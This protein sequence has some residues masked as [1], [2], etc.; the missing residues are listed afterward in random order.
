MPELRLAGPDL[1]PKG[2][3]ELAVDLTQE[4]ILLLIRELAD[5]QRRSADRLLDLV[6]KAKAG[7]ATWRELGTATGINHQTLIYQVESDSPV[8]VAGRSTRGRGT[9]APDPPHRRATGKETGAM[10]RA[11]RLRGE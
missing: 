9:P 4:E 7:G 2:G 8:V 11:R 10:W 5:A 1:S 3:V 6:R